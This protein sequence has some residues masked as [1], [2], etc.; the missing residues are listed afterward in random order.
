MP[1]N[2]RNEGNKCNHCGMVYIA[3]AND[4]DWTAIPCPYCTIDWLCAELRK[5]EKKIEDR[6][7]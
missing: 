4:T 1:M 3:P 7:T 6:K 5:L 2:Q